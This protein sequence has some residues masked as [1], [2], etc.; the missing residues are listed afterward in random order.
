MRQP[1]RSLGAPEWL[2]LVGAT[3]FIVV[4]AVSA[5][6]D[7]SI[8]WLHFFQSWMYVATIALCLRRNR[9]GYFIGISV[10]ALWDYGSLFVN[11]FFANGVRELAN[12]ISTGHLARP[13][14]FIA[15]P[16]WTANL[17]VVVGC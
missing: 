16:A 11:T 3:A 5:V 6:F 8:R 13:D 2:V 14:Q 9:W 12:W 17:L 15:V 7:A 10:A 1:T 4:L